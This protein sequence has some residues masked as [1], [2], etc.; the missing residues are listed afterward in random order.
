M[1]GCLRYSGPSFSRGGSQFGVL[2]SL[3]AGADAIRAIKKLVGQKN[4]SV[5]DAYRETVEV[6]YEKRDILTKIAAS[7]Q[8]A[9]NWP[10]CSYGSAI[11]AYPTDP[12]VNEMELLH[13]FAGDHRVARRRLREFVEEKDQRKRWRQTSVRRPSDDGRAI[14][15]PSEQVQLRSPDA[16]HSRR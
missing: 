12:I 11:G 3:P 7:L 8:V 5:Q 14:D 4:Y 16:I 1:Y 10:W 2:Q 13:L 15:T 6:A 9:E